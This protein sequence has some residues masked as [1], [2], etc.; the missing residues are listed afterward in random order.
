MS[1]G[2]SSLFSSLS[3]RSPYEAGLSPGQ[4]AGTFAAD[5]LR[6]AERA[7]VRE[8]GANPQ[9]V[10]DAEAKKSHAEKLEKALAGTVQYMT[11]N[12]GDK[13]GTAMMGLVY[14]RLGDGPVTE[15]TLGRALVDVAKF[16]D[17]NFGIAEGDGFMEHLNGDL[18]KSLNA[19]FDNGLNEEFFAASSLPGQAGNA[20]VPSALGEKIRERLADAMKSILDSYTELREKSGFEEYLAG[21]QPQDPLTLYQGLAQQP[22]QGILLD[23]AA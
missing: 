10:A 8:E 7:G 15:E 23:T 5:I 18:N 2:V 16:V 21:K 1:Y 17:R 14:K 22:A 4:T 12:F 19:Y 11:D 20:A 9:P 6:Q 3:V 13:A